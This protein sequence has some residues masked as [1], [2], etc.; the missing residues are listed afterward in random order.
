MYAI[1]V[2]RRRAHEFYNITLCINVLAKIVVITVRLVENND[3]SRFRKIGP[4]GAKRGDFTRKTERRRF[5]GP[6]TGRKRTENRRRKKR[7][8]SS[9]DGDPVDSCKRPVRTRPRRVPG[10][11]VITTNLRTCNDNVVI[12]ET[13][14]AVQRPTKPARARSVGRATACVKP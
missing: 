9:R 3:S 5:R 1:Q 13:D 10:L 11:P 12:V 14:A 8:K 7:R 2:G 4:T 6:R